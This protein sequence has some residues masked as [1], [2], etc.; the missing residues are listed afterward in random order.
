M[1][2][3]L[4]RQTW[5]L[6]YATACLSLIYWPWNL[7]LILATSGARLLVAWWKAASVDIILPV[8]AVMCPRGPMMDKDRA[9]AIAAIAARGE[10]IKTN[11]AEYLWICR[12]IK[13]ALPPPDKPVAT[14]RSNKLDQP[15]LAR[16]AAV[17]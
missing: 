12:G 14:D 6:V 10:Q 9:A 15:Q 13:P 16:S 2:L 4:S 1:R 8:E 5:L 7:L 11:S 17:K 3:C